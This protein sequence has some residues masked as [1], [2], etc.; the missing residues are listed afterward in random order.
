MHRRGCLCGR[1]GGEVDEGPGWSLAFADRRDSN[2]QVASEGE[3]V[4]VLR[5]I[6]YAGR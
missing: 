4:D 6:G 1:L 5:G 3:M 2:T